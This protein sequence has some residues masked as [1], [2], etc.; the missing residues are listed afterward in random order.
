MVCIG[1]DRQEWHRVCK[2]GLSVSSTQL[3][4]MVDFIVMVASTVLVDPRIKSDTDV[5]VLG[6]VMRRAL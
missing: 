6:H 2:G 3:H 4:E 1:T 5:S